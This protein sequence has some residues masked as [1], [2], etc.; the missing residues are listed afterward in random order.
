M[1]NKINLYSQHVTSSK[2][3][4]STCHVSLIAQTDGSCSFSEES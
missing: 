3:A 2:N 1:K 4:N